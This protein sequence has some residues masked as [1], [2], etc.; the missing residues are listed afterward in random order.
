M[1]TFTVTSG[2]LQVT[3]PSYDLT[4][5][6]TATLDNV[7]NGLYHAA[8]LREDQGVWG[9]RVTHLEIWH[10]SVNNKKRRLKWQW[11]DS[12]IGVDTGI[13]GFFDFQKFKEIKEQSALNKTFFDVVSEFSNSVDHHE[14]LEYG[15]MSSTGFGDG[16]YAL[17]VAED[18][19]EVVAARIV[20]IVEDNDEFEEI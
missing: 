16:V 7:R 17:Y 19:G 2:K 20:F 3:D 9:D 14:I 15:T 4:V 10:D 11:R 18:K 13:A 1:S 12:N 6:C 5:W 8:V